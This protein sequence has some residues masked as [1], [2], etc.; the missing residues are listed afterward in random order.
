MQRHDWQLSPAGGNHVATAQTQV[1]F[2]TVEESGAVL[3]IFIY[4]SE[5]NTP[6]LIASMLLAR[7]KHLKYHHIFSVRTA[8]IANLSDSV[9][10]VSV[11]RSDAVLQ[12]RLNISFKSWTA[13]NVFIFQIY[14]Q[15]WMHSLLIIP[16]SISDSTERHRQPSLFHIFV[17]APT[18][19]RLS[20]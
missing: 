14:H 18:T 17:H 3:A 19:A 12:F 15:K 8:K 9:W 6:S 11:R 7:K 20:N 16:L 5:E 4:L 10:R 1:Y 13:F 2:C